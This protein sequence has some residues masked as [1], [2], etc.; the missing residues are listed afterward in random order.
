MIGLSPLLLIPAAYLL[1]NGLPEKPGA[2]QPHLTDQDINQIH[3]KYLKT[4]KQ[5]K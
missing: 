5:K 3:Q 2:Y 1:M 4:I